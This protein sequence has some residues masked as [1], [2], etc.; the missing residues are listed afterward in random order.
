MILIH[1]ILNISLVLSIFHI[2]WI[3]IPMLNL[4][5]LMK[6][7]MNLIKIYYQLIMN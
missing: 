5:I 3:I 4:V 2:L 7:L 6:H 1:I